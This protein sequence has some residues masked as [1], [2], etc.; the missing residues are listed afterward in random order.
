MEYK[1]YVAYLRRS[2]KEQS[3]S[4]G[5][6]A[7]ETEVARYVGA[8]NGQII[9]TFVEIESGT[10]KKLSKRT[11]IWD[12]IEECKNEN[13]IL[14]IAKLD[15]LARDVEFTSRLMNSGVRFVACDIPQANEFTIHVMAAVAEQEAK[16][17]SERTKA[18]LARKIARGAKLGWLSHK[19]RSGCPFDDAARKK[20][21]ETNRNKSLSNPNNTRARGYA[22][23]LQ[24]RGKGL[25]EIANIMN[26]E[27]FRSPYGNKISAS[28]VLRWIQSYESLVSPAHDTA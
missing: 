21:G 22:A 27:G 5:L 14:I 20:A 12:A 24:K 15:R 17:I 18:A 8:N 2:K 11:I 1:K 28:T 13:A 4:L 26:M 23:S 16:R 9:R 6:D 10:S 7:Q 3:S 25:Q 19:T